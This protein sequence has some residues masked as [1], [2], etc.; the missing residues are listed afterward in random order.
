MYE[1]RHQTAL[2]QQDENMKREEMKAAVKGMGL[3]KIQG[4]AAPVNNRRALGDIGNLVGAAAT[5]GLTELQNMEKKAP[6]P[7]IDRPVTRG[8]GA[9]LA[10]TF[11]SGKEECKAMEEALAAMS[12]MKMSERQEDSGEVNAPPGFPPRNKEN[13][14]A[15]RVAAPGK[16]RKG[17]TLTATLTARSEATCG[18]FKTE[19][20]EDPVANIDADDVGNQLAVVDYIDDIYSFYRRTEKQ[21]CVPPN[22]M[23]QQVHINE[24]MRAVLIDWLIE[25][26]YKYKLMP[27]TLFLTTNLID[28]Y[29]AL[30]SVERKCLQLVGMTAM[31]IASKYEEIWAPEIKDLILISDS[32]YS[33][34]QILDMEKVM[35]NV[36]RF[37]L[38]IPTP[39][40]F[41]VRF[42]KAAGADRQMSLLAFYF[43]EL[44]LVDYAM[45][46]FLPS[47]LA[48]SAVYLAR[49]TLKSGQDARW[50]ATLRW[51][52][53]YKEAQLIECASLIVDLHKKAGEGNVTVV[54]RKGG[55]C[56]YTWMELQPRLPVRKP[57]FIFHGDGVGG[58]YGVMDELLPP[59]TIYKP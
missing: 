54:H 2:L 22:Y 18:S 27:E 28:Q 44:C 49:H 58:I 38:C 14:R 57:Y 12:Q 25:V 19:V 48:A 32:A 1:T 40:M 39:Y 53:G 26:H 43:V 59:F 52:S 17:R 30:K 50:N 15:K 6:L 21:S 16:E 23:S 4:Q 45:L 56:C 37:N 8:Y 31:L 9:R 47:M 46:G 51:H 33:R 36:L 10:E 11:L 29:L 34:Q 20:A 3:A 41:L 35:L 13:G 24:K 55:S 5:E 42:L 7:V